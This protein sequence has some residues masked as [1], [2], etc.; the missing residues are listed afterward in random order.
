MRGGS[1]WYVKM[2]AMMVA[3]WTMQMT[4][5]LDQDWNLCVV[6]RCEYAQ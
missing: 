1:S 6:L 5:G 2:E 4:H 3:V